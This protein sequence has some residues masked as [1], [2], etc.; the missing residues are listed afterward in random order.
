MAMLIIAAAAYVGLSIMEKN[1][2]D[3]VKRYEET[4]W[5]AYYAIN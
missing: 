4:D 2:E 3:E 1:Y 5:N